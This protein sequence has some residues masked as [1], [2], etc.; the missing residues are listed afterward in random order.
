MPFKHG[1]LTTILANGYDVS[2]YFRDAE[3]NIG[4]PPVDST[5]FGATW[6]TK[7]PGLNEAS[8]TFD[9]LYDP[10]ET[11]IQAALGS[12]GGILT[13]CPGGGAAA[14]DMARIIPY[15]SS[16]W[17]QSDPVD[18]AAA[19]S[20]EITAEGAAAFGQVLHPTA[21][22]VPAAINGGFEANATGWN[23]VGAGSMAR[24]TAEFNTGIACGR[25]TAT[26]TAGTGSVYPITGTF[27]SGRTYR[28]TFWAKTISGTTSWLAQ[29][30]DLGAIDATNFPF[31]ATGSFVKSTVE[32]TPSANRTAV[33]VTFSNVPAVAGVV[34]VDDVSV[35]LLDAARDDGAAT[36]TGWTMAGH[37]IGATG[38]SWTFV[39]Q[40][41]A[42]GAAGSWADVTGASM[43]VTAGGTAQRIVSSSATATLRRYVR[44]V[45]TFTYGTGTAN[46]YTMTYQIAYARTQ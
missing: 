11:A 44:I 4:K 45:P 12:G 3:L 39:L 8:M 38:G 29:L 35:E 46:G 22:N 41:S 37:F 13:Y 1:R 27:L 21:V 20:W 6:R 5:T 42:T 43:T 26:G 30:G 33:S 31:T 24:S 25:V 18:D 34:A 28:L 36:S 9:G 10:T 40:D 32:W 14:G 7:I 2:G 16:G 23:A 19:V 17:G 15:A